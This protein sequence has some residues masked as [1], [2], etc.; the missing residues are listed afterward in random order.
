MKI[1]PPEHKHG[2][3]TTCYRHHRCRCEGCRAAWNAY[4]RAWAERRRAERI[5]PYAVELAMDGVQV[6]M[7]ARQREE[8][9]HILWG[10]RWSD[11]AIAQQLHLAD[12][13]V[14]RIR[15]RLGLPGW[16][17]GVQE[18]QLRAA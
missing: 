8:A 6:W 14:L 9:V 11:R 13:T 3:T 15:A 10:Y 18:R 7:T 17:V 16:P 2:V 1:C 5:D 12:R 4:H